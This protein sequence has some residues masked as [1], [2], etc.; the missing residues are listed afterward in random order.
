MAGSSRDTLYH[1]F[2][3]IVKRLTADWA[4][5][6][7]TVDYHRR[8]ALVVEAPG[9]SSRAHRGGPLRRDRREA[10]R[11]EVAFVVRDAWQNRGL[12]TILFDEILRAAAAKSY[13]RF[14]AYVLADNR[15]MLDLITRFTRV[16]SR[17]TEQSV[18]ELVFTLRPKQA[19]TKT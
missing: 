7:A 5:I 8:L 19:T 4:Q 15:R 1:R 6:L 17:K 9:A 16:E 14:R 18:T 11:S 12:G 2:F 10:T 3:T 13:R